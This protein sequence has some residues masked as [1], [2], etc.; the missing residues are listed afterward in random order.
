M[1]EECKLPLVGRHHSGIDDSKNI[2]AVALNL[3]ERGYEFT[4]GMAIEENFKSTPAE[5]NKPEEKSNEES[6]RNEDIK[7]KGATTN[8]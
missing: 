2:A 3:I 5:Y 8:Y 4:Q 7:R 1:L 6:K